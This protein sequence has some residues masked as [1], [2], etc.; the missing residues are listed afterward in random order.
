MKEAVECFQ[1]RKFNESKKLFQKELE[2]VLSIDEKINIYSYLYEISQ[3]I[4]SPIQLDY[5]VDFLKIAYELNN[6]EQYIVI[7]EASMHEEVRSNITF[8]LQYFKCLSDSGRV[9]KSLTEAKDICFIVVDKKYYN[10]ASEVFDTIEKSYRGYLFYEFGRLI[11]AIDTADS[12]KILKQINIISQKLVESWSLLNGKVKSQEGY[13]KHLFSLLKESS[14][15]DFKLNKEILLLKC[16]L[17][18]RFNFLTLSKKEVME[19][20]VVFSEEPEEFYLLVETVKDEFLGYDILDYLKQKNILDSLRYRLKK[21]RKN[22]KSYRLDEVRDNI[23]REDILNVEYEEDSPSLL[24]DYGIQETQDEGILDLGAC[25]NKTDVEL[26]NLFYALCGIGYLNGASQVIKKVSNKK[27][28]IFLS[29]YLF[30]LRE[31][32]LGLVA[33]ISEISIEGRSLSTY[34]ILLYGLEKL[35]EWERVQNIKSIIHSVEIE[36]DELLRKLIHE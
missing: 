20:L 18:R 23:Y 12:E 17:S 13:L 11:W 29:C 7:F 27:N 30:E 15:N 19:F 32:F 8:K 9:Q 24:L 14:L 34:K 4:L 35:K 3:K 16:K 21:V 26:I 22:Y 10:R 5:T 6:Y 1:S 36:Q 31:D 33:Y 2:K 28:Q 25:E